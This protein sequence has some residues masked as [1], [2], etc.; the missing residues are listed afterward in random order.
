MS[1]FLKLYDARLS[2]NG[3]SI[4]DLDNLLNDLRNDT[5]DKPLIQRQSSWKQS[6]KSVEQLIDTIDNGLKRY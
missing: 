1:L 5:N 2:K 4:T 6:R 3:T